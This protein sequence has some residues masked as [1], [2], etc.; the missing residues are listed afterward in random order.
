MR[1]WSS[2]RKPSITETI[3]MRRDTLEATTT[4]AAKVVILE[5]RYLFAMNHRYMDRGL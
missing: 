2:E 1:A 3:T 5:K 4:S